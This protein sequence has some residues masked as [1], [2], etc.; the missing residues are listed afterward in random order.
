MSVVVHGQD[1]RLISGP[2]CAKSSDDKSYNDNV[3]RLLHLLVN[4]TKKMKRR[5][6]HE[7][8]SYNHNFPNKD[9]GSVAGGAVCDGH[10]WGWQCESCLRSARR[11]I[12]KG[13]GPSTEASVYLE[14]CSVWFKKIVAA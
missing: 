1:T 14:D 10:M 11:K 6:S 5:S 2:H 13:C 3:A 9:V 8:F 7:N 12:F 4:D